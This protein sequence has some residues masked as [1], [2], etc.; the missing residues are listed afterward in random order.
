MRNANGGINNEKTKH[1]K[2]LHLFDT[3]V[4]ITSYAVRLNF[5]KR[6]RF[7]VSRSHKYINGDLTKMHRTLVYKC[8]VAFVTH[9]LAQNH[10]E[11]QQLCGY[12]LFLEKGKLHR[13]FRGH[14]CIYEDLTK[15]HRTLLYK[16]WEVKSNNRL[17]CVHCSQESFILSASLNFEK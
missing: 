16:C 5:L 6:K 4:N 3:I 17:I 9:I 13:V 8:S 12:A 14:K 11:Y 7:I 15:M 2:R 10:R 1:P